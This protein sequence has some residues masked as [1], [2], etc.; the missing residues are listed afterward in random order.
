MAQIW[1]YMRDSA[2]VG[3]H[4]ENFTPRYRIFLTCKTS[5]TDP[6][7]FACTPF[8]TCLELITCDSSRNG[9]QIRVKINPRVASLGQNG[10]IAADLVNPTRG[11]PLPFYQTLPRSPASRA[12]E[13]R[14]SQVRNLVDF[15]AVAPGSSPVT[16]CAYA[17][18]AIWVSHT[19]LPGWGWSPDS[20]QTATSPRQLLKLVPGLGGRGPHP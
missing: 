5:L 14:I 16:A 3:P 13:G 4:L 17:T 7:R 8:E 11:C 10:K 15:G 9:K 18:E 1:R 20:S 6:L 19:P 12:N 2:Y